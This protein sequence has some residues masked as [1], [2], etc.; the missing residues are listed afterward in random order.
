[1]D[2]LKGTLGIEAT[3]E[4]G[5]VK[6]A[7]RHADSLRTTYGRSLRH[8]L[9]TTD[10]TQPQETS[11]R[12]PAKIQSGD[13]LQLPPAPASSSM[14]ASTTRQ[15]YEHQQQCK[16]LADIEYVIDFVM[17]LRVVDPLQAQVLHAMRTP[18]AQKIS[19]DARTAIKQTERSKALAVLVS[20]PIAT[21]V[22][23]M[24]E[25]RTNLPTN[26]A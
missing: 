8:N 11:G 1:M 19:E 10:Y 18:G 12:L 14:L 5:C 23:P 13:F 4:L 21:H 6:G 16:L 2:R 26:G 7:L 22:S 17:M 3:D 25:A 9:P 15:S 20:P 24:L